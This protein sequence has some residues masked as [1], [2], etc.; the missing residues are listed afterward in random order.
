MLEVL[1]LFISLAIQKLEGFCVPAG[2]QV[3]FISL[4]LPK[5]VGEVYLNDLQSYFC[6]KSNSVSL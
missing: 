3:D 5:F 2:K 6:V 1:E 4:A